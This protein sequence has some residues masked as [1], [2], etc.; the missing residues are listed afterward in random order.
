MAN[1][2][3][4][5]GYVLLKRPSRETDRMYSVLTRAHGKLE[6]HAQGSRKVLSKL[7]GEMEV[8]GLLDIFVVHGRSFDRLAGASA[9]TSHS[10]I[11]DSHERMLALMDAGVF[12]DRVIRA[13][14]CDEKLWQLYGEYLTT[15]AAASDAVVQE[16]RI[17]T[18]FLWKVFSCLGFHPDFVHCLRCR[19]IL[20]TEEEPI[21]SVRH[22]GLVCQRC[23]AGMLLVDGMPFFADLHRALTFFVEAPLAESARLFLDMPVRT[24]VRQLT[25][26]WCE[27]HADVRAWV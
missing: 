19:K 6:L 13:G 15:I 4:T 10:A 16:G 20:T 5:E 23:A 27:M 3:R 9:M 14:E 18:A 7:S 12:L 2:F 1:T 25:R 11:R 8:P 17:A 22:G 26:A 24:A 21:I